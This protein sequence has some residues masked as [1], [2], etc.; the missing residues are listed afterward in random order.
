MPVLTGSHSTSCAVGA[1]LRISSDMLQYMILLRN[2]SKL[3]KTMTVAS[4]T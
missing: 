3:F 4:Y 1:K 2:K